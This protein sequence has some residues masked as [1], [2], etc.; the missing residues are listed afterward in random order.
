MLETLSIAALLSF[1]MITLH[2]SMLS[3]MFDQPKQPH[4]PP[5]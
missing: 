4:I 3:S 2:K 1:V 5:S